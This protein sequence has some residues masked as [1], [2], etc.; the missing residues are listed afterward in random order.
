MEFRSLGQVVTTMGTRKTK[1]ITIIDRQEEK[2]AFWFSRVENLA[3]FVKCFSKY[4][5]RDYPNQNHLENMCKCS[6]LGFT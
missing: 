4:K 3:Y 1:L 6:V 2:C 5:F